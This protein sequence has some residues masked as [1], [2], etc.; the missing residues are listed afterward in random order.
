MRADAGVA[1][2]GGLLGEHFVITR[3]ART[4]I[5]VESAGRSRHPARVS[6]KVGAPQST[7]VGSTHPG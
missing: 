6:R 7:V 2:V 4:L 3:L 5:T 1:R